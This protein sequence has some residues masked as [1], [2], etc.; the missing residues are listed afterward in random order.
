MTGQSQ[1]VTVP[2]D[3]TLNVAF[4]NCPLCGALVPFS[5]G[6]HVCMNSLSDYYPRRQ[7]W[8]LPL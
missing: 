4:V 3:P 1:P 5:C 2:E 8:G 7:G 6:Q